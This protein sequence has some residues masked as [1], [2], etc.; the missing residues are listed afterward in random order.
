MQTNQLTEQTPLRRVVTLGSQ[1]KQRDFVILSL[2]VGLARTVIAAFQIDK[3]SRIYDNGTTSMDNYLQN[4]N[5]T[6][7]FS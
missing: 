6:E 7:S 2:V 3:M 1:I 4:Y 5:S